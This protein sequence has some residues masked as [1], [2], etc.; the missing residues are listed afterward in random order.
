MEEVEGIVEGAR[1]A[2]DDCGAVEKAAGRSRSSAAGEKGAM[3]AGGSVEG[4]LPAMVDRYRSA[5]PRRGDLAGVGKEGCYIPVLVP[6]EGQRR[7]A[8]EAGCRRGLL[9]GAA[10]GEAFDLGLGLARLIPAC[11]RAFARPVRSFGLVSGWFGAT[12]GAKGKGKGKYL[13]WLGVPVPFHQV[14]D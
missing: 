7:Q 12:L 1:R 4:G 6:G 3:G 14:S 11:S 5:R 10:R 9:A 8:R 13:L 2:G